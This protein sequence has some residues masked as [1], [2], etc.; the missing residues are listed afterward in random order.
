MADIIGFS[1]TIVRLAV[2]AG[3]GSM[4]VACQPFGPSRSDVM[5]TGRLTASTEELAS[6][7]EV[8]QVDTTTVS[9]IKPATPVVTF[10]SVLDDARPIGTVVGVGDALEVSIWEAPP[11]TLFGGTASDTRIGTAIATARPTV[12]PEALVGPEGDISVPFA[13]RVPAAGRTLREIENDIT[14]RLRG[15]ANAPQVLVRLVRNATANVTV[16]GDVNQAG[17]LPLTPRGERL[18]DALATAGGVRPPVNLATIQVTRNGHSY[19]MPLSEIL[20]RDENNIVLARDDVVTVLFQPYSFTVLGASAR[21]DEI[22]F[23]AMGITMAQALARVG[24]LQDGR[25][26]PRGVFIF[27]W[28]RPE[29]QGEPMKPVIYSFDLKDPAAYFLVQQFPM[30]DRDLVYITNSPVAEL[31]RFVS[32][33]ASTILP[34]ATVTTVAQQ[35]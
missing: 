8:V 17:R 23:E 25:G 6:S 4:L 30:R 3:F 18:L 33:V 13:G 19:R 10:A 28:E 35:N 15:R 7:I 32:I 11:A 22:R 29:T 21:N 31:Q 34:L 12:L 5:T 16:V 9:R 20:E 2:V 26:D 27:R 14:E 1:R 24:G